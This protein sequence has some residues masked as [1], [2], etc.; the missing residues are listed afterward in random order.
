MHRCAFV[1]PADRFRIFASSLQHDLPAREV[2]RCALDSFVT[3]YDVS[4]WQ[5]AQLTAAVHNGSAGVDN[6]PVR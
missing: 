6:D 4:P 2:C 5:I 3:P 1:W